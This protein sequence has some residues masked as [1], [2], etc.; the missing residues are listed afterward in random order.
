LSCVCLRARAPQRAGR[1]LHRLPTLPCQRVQGLIGDAAAEVGARPPGVL[2]AGHSSLRF[3][4]AGEFRRLLE[5][6]GLANISL[7]EPRQTH[8]VADV[9][10][11][12][13]GAIGGMALISSMIIHPGAPTQRAIRA[14]LG[15]MAAASRTPRGLQ[16]P[17]AFR[18]GA[19][20][21]PG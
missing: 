21:K 10:A 12:W 15:G 13:N 16:L 6:A 4:D 20:R 2:P 8:L 3:T 17:V 11:L 19:G 9:D 1:R 7:A 14:A 5:G 18:V